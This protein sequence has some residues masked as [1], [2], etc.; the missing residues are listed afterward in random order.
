MRRIPQNT[1]AVILLSGGVDSTTS[2]Y[3]AKKYGYQLAALIFDY[4]QRH[5]KEINA[6]I[7]IAKLNNVPYH[8]VKVDIPWTKSALTDSTVKVPFNRNLS[9]RSVPP[10]YVSGRNIIFLSYAASFA[11]SVGA[12]KIFIG[13]HVQDYSG[14]PDC[15]PQFLDAMTN[16][17]NLGISK[18]GIDIVYPLID[19]NKK[20]IIKM[21]LSLNV[22]FEYTWSCYLGRQ[23]PCGK[24]DSCRFRIQAFESLGMRDP[25]LKPKRKNYAGKNR[26][27]FQKHSG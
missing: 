26:R 25:L 16:A 19:K 3:M 4:A 17:V 6:A 10:T 14:Y 23:L 7:K 21:G 15:R 1:K 9:N 18:K 20:D 22:P 12:E 8:V 5:R 2:L 11:E 24:C 27:S 13:A